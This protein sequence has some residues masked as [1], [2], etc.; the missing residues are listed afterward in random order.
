M[1]YIFQCC[2]RTSFQ[3]ASLIS[4][5]TLFSGKYTARAW[6]SIYT[7]QSWLVS[8]KKFLGFPFSDTEITSYLTFTCSILAGRRVKIPSPA[9]LFTSI[10]V[11]N[12]DPNTMV[13]PLQET[14][15]R[16][17]WIFSRFW[18]RQGWVWIWLFIGEYSVISTCSSPLDLERVE[19]PLTKGKRDILL[20]NTWFWKCFHH[21]VTDVL[22]VSGTE[23]S[24]FP[25][26]L[27][28]VQLTRPRTAVKMINVKARDWEVSVKIRRQ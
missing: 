17:R 5:Q 4:E 1:E 15:V 28:E 8:S 22:C 16:Q 18:A 11:A 2:W 10:L 24:L 19:N 7:S 3:D 13:P 26:S 14:P 27:Q 21:S 23:V 9:L 6:L 25:H 12:M 20:G